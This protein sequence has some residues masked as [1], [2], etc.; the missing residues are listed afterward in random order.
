[1][2]VSFTWASGTDDVVKRRSPRHPTSVWFEIVPH[3]VVANIAHGNSAFRVSETHPPAG[4]GMAERAG[5]EHRLRRPGQLEA[6]AEPLRLG[7]RKTREIAGRP[8]PSRLSR[9]RAF[10]RFGLEQTHAI[11]FRN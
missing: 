8:D 7:A 2:R 3:H 9:P 11:H 5:A 10:H 4:A 1:M 6:E